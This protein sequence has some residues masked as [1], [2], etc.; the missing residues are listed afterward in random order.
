MTV[1]FFLICISL[2]DAALEGGKICRYFISLRILLLLEY[3][4]IQPAVT[5]EAGAVKMKLNV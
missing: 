4:M 2:Q 3:L 5:A 1:E